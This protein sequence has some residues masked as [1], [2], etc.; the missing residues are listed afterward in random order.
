MLRFE[1]SG[2]IWR[3]GRAVECTGLENRRTLI[4]FPGFES[5]ALHQHQ[6]KQRL[7][8]NLSLFFCLKFLVVRTQARSQSCNRKMQQIMMHNVAHCCIFC[9]GVFYVVAPYSEIKG[10]HTVTTDKFKKHVD[11]IQTSRSGRPTFRLSSADGVMCDFFDTW[12]Y[13]LAAT[14]KFKTVK[15]Y[16]YAVCGFLNYIEEIIAQRGELTIPLMRDALDSYESFL[17]F[18]EKSDSKLAASVAKKIGGKNLSGASVEIHFSA[19]NRF[20]DASESLRI[21]IKELEDGGYLSEKLTSSIP[22]TTSRYVGAPA[23]V[24]SAIKSKSWL[25]GCISGGAARVKRAGLSPKSKASTLAHTNEFGGDEKTFPI[26]KCLEL[27][28]S[29]ECLRDRVLWSLIAA[30]GCRISEALTLLIDDIYIDPKDPSRNKVLIVDPATRKD[31]LIHYIPASDIEKL[32]H[33]GRSTPTTYLIEPFA[34]MFWQCLDSYIEDERNKEKIRHNPLRHRF[35]FRNLR[36]GEPMPL[37]YQTV[38]ERFNKAA[39]ALTGTSYGF[40][41]LRHMYAYYLVNHCPNPINPGRYGL[42]LK[43]VQELLGH[44]SI[45]VTRR[46]ARQDANM[47]EATFAAINMLRMRDPFFSVTNVR[48]RHLEIELERLK[49]SLTLGKGD[50]ND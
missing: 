50:S 36:T 4:A 37:S 7:R 9:Y 15:A 25:A 39:I 32:E 6:Q 46:Y 13:Q 11:L 43:Q 29:A 14:L 23:H 8:Q 42:E 12:A 47:L 18:G 48:I 31:V 38:W 2:K 33:K 44:R 22:L 3:V 20:I 41:S 28:K 17:V 34:S 16:C 19:I 21:A 26:D 1:R 5:Q 45:N 35:L 49:K 10:R 24:K 40:H 27:I 30:S